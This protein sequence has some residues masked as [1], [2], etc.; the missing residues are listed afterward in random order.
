MLRLGAGYAGLN[1]QP[2]T[3]LK[4][5]VTMKFSLKNHVMFFVLL[6]I[7]LFCS[8]LYASDKVW[9]LANISGDIIENAA[10]KDSLDNVVVYFKKRKITLNNNILHVGNESCQVINKK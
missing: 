5:R 4:V 3:A 7:P 6:V 8:S 2:F 10:N 9:Q 1:K